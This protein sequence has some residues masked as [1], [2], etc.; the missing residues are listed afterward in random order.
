MGADSVETVDA[1]EALAGLRVVHLGPCDIV[2]EKPAA[3]QASHL[4]IKELARSL[5]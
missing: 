1:I 5:V 3:G 4:R 2:T